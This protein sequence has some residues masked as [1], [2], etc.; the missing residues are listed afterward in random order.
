MEKMSPKD[1]YLL[2]GK[3]TKPHGLRGEVKIYSFS[4]QPENFL[5][6]KELT[7]CD[8][9]G[10]LTGPMAVI[11]SRVQGNTAV[12]KFAEIVDRS[13]AENIG[14]YEVFLLKEH[15][16]AP[17]PGEYYWQQYEGKQLVHKDGAVIGIVKELF[18]SGAQDIFVVDTGNDEVMIPV[19]DDFIVEE[20][21]NTIVV[22]LPPGLL[23]INVSPVK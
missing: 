18:N 13:A 1:K 7:L 10:Q 16:P 21:D 11:K 6:Y 3:T 17:H 15:L 23:E 20:T 8:L 4:G 12:V 14:G 9:K 5:E 2:V 19:I 22:N